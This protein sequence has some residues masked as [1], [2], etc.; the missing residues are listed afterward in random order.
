MC[1]GLDSSWSDKAFP[2]R[3]NGS[4]LLIFV[5]FYFLHV[6]RSTIFVQAGLD[7]EKGWRMD[8]NGRGGLVVCGR[9]TIAFD[10]G[11]IC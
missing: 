2:E 10:R 7:L 3:R 4:G 1:N 6:G 8:E 11:K 5:D 9:P